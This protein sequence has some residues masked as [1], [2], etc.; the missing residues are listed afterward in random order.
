MKDLTAAKYKRKDAQP[1]KKK[2][3]RTT[4]KEYDK[5]DL[6]TFALCDAMRYIRAFEAGKPPTVPKYELAIKLAS[7]KSGATVR[8]RLRLPHPILTALRICVICPPDS[9]IA[10]KAR[11][12]GATLVGDT[13]VIAAVKEGRVEFDRCIAHADSITA[14]SKAGVG[15][16]LGPRGLMPSAKTGT[17]VTD[18]AKTVRDMIGASEYRERV[19]VVRLA[20]GQLGFSPEEMMRNV[21]AVVEQV[22]K[23]IA[24]LS[25]RVDKRI[26]EIVLSS[27][28]S[29]GFPLSNEFKSDESPPTKELSTM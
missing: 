13:A 4:Y 20:V 3:A 6:M 21:K 26:D 19:G 1:A 17:V 15:R 29:P 27:S 25:D 10:A 23:D 18:V 22:K 2:K 7:V 16:V 24:A 9:P 8:N 12:A 11:A 14:F 28:H 5:K